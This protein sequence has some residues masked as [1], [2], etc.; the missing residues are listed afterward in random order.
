M[1]HSYLNERLLFLL[2]FSFLSLC[3]YS[4]KDDD[5]PQVVQ[6]PES[7]KTINEINDNSKALQRLVVAQEEQ[8]EVKLCVAI[9]SSSYSVELSD[10]NTCTI[11][12]E[13]TALGK[14]EGS[15]YAPGIGARKDAGTYY[16]TI[17]NDWLE[18]EDTKVPVIQ[19]HSSTPIL[20]IDK[21]GYWTVECNG[22]LLT[23]NRKAEEG[24]LKSIF[25]Q[26]DLTTVG[27]VTF[28]LSDGN[29]P[30]TL[31]L[32]DKD[33][34][35][36]VTGHL[37]RP[38]SPE[39]PAWFIHI[40]TWNTADAQK[41]IDL[42]P[43]DI[44]PYVIFNIGLSVSH[45]DTTGEFNIVEYGYETAKSWLRTCA[46]NNV[47]A[48][49]QPAS[50][51]FCHFP[52]YAT[53]AEMENSVF[54]EFFRDYPNFLGFNYCEQFWGFDDKFSVTYPQRLQHWTNLMSLTHKYG[55]YLTIS[56]CGPHWGASLTPV[57]MFK[58]DANF[59]TVCREHPENL[60]V[61]E[62]YTSTYGFFNIE[63]ACLG[64]WLSGYAGQYGMRFDQCGW[65]ARNWNGDEEFPVAAGAIPMIE[66]I[67][68]TGQTV[69][70]GPELIWQQDFKEVNASGTDNGY[71]QRN[72]ECFPQFVNINIDIYRKILDGTIRIMSRQE[73]IDRT[74][75]VVINDVTPT[76]AFSDP[77]YL[78]PITLYDGLY[79]LDEDGVN[80]NQ[81]LYF[82]KTGRY[83]TLP[84]VYELVDDV[85]KS[86]L[87]K[88]NA[89]QFESGYG[90]VQM[91]QSKFNRIFPEEY[92]GNMYVGRH[93]N[94]WVAYNAYADNRNASIPFK[95]NTCEKMELAFAKYSVSVIKEYADKA[96]FYL[97]N[98]SEKGTMK[99]NVIKIYG[100]NAKPSFTYQDRATPASCSITDDWSNGV[101]TL[102]VRHN[103]AVDITV[104]CSGNGTGR[105]TQYQLASIT[106]PAGPEIYQGSRQYEAE[107]F[108]YKNIAKVHKNVVRE[109]DRIRNYTA[110]G[111]LNFGSR[112]D[113]AVR[114][115]ITVNDAGNYILRMRYNAASTINTVDLYVNGAKVATPE[116]AQSGGDN[117]SWTTISSPVSL[118]AGK[119][120]FELKA[121]APASC[122]LYLD[123]MIVE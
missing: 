50:G 24:K 66:H 13:V 117:V 87:Y 101:Y 95:Y 98:Y 86:F 72:W 64:A 38:I 63:S 59:A 40:D 55:G 43:I 113:A 88:I 91:K 2:F 46:E 90:D 119:N 108:D 80:E 10:G 22:K 114:D 35:N 109:A 71:T 96:T 78:A 25:N 76:N 58:R 49:V 107:C 69:Y 92:S 82:K 103:G 21:E 111:Y 18:M 85:A 4:C 19:E 39:Q 16:W 116:F 97:T 94:A 28:R 106:T 27:R 121:S 51:G 62:K 23:L 12:T 11:L 8:M 32:V 57:A 42:I 104:I 52:D 61:C 36:P 81:T 6:L 79:R 3:F 122:D 93:E 123:N 56:F 31:Q 112:S 77:G 5:I 89:S 84:V 110:M 41:I 99:T 60:I 9:T 118:K 14:G 74:K 83:P 73:V 20:G 45:D 37:R 48:V 30:I 33:K 26:V 102:T 34:P 17:D 115:Y 105:E 75:F 67:M 29:L 7:V 15:V 120:M 100:S 65:N 53:L 54:D 70:D 47:W 68:L 44:R 1:K